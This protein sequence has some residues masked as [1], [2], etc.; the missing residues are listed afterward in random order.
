[1]RTEFMTNAPPAGD[2]EDPFHAYY[3]GGIRKIG[4]IGVLAAL[5]LMAV[6][7]AGSVGAAGLSLT[8]VFL[9]VAHAA[10]PSIFGAPG[11]EMAGA[12]V[13]DIRM[14]RILLAGFAGA[15]LAVAGAVM[16][17]VLRN[18]LVS[19]FTL[20]LSSAASF[21]AALAIVAGPGI[22][23]AL[24]V[25]NQN[26]LIV[27][28]AFAFGIA[29]MLLIYAVTR[30]SDDQSTIILA[31]VVLGYMFSAGV[32]VLKYLTNNEKLRDITL[33]LMGGMWGANWGSAVLVAI[34]TVLV[35]LLLTLKA[36]D[37]NALSAG[38]E[39]ARN[40][41]VDIGRTRMY[42]LLLATLMASSCMAFTGVIGF[43]GL[44]SPHIC[45]I[46]IGNDHRYLIPCSALMGALI[47]L[48]SDTFAR[49]IMIPQD[50][51]VGI[52]M[53]VIG[54][55]FFLFLIRRGKRSTLY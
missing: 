42:C 7:Y 32:L 46:I 22:M 48:L 31:G 20:G 27:A 45:R 18:P 23:G 1:M 38:D 9:A 40:L 5:L 33:W 8:D 54:G 41:G 51:P 34:V 29:S 44:M 50:L 52:V 16:Q 26:A 6:V 49:T 55:A 37:L 19:P 30:M 17:G 11:N 53:Y 14:P 28:M 43:V 39:V 36:W 13:V 47:L 35:L 21:G 2:A 15:S 12:I 3:S 4:L 10:L 24:F 25:G